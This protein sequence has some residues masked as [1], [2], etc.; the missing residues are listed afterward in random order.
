[1][2]IK[3][4]SLCVD[5]FQKSHF[6]HH[7]IQ[8]LSTTSMW[9]SVNSSNVSPEWARDDPSKAWILIMK[10]KIIMLYG[11]IQYGRLPNQNYSY[12][13]S[14]K[15]AHC[16]RRNTKLAPLGS[17]L[18]A[19]GW[20]KAAQGWRKA[21]PGSAEAEQGCAG[22]AAS[23]R[24]IFLVFFWVESEVSLCKNKLKNLEKKKKT[25]TKRPRAR[26]R[27]PT[28][29]PTLPPYL[30]SDAHSGTWVAAAGP[31]PP[32]ATAKEEESSFKIWNCWIR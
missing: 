1:M 31:P 17:N 2:N 23:R 3:L 18:A 26:V 27:P 28:L 6:W 21:A 22:A 7:T 11:I 14:A 24:G 19:Q 20:R 9:W 12:L 16:Q 5:D 25:K 15:V 8:L 29:L 32:P 4:T 13:G 30:A 10:Q